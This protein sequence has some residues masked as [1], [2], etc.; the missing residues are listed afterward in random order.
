MLEITNDNVI[1]LTKGDTGVINI[2]VSGS[3]L[4]PESELVFTVRNAQNLDNI[5]FQLTETASE[6]GIIE[7]AVNDTAKWKVTIYGAATN[8]LKRKKYYY[9]FAIVTGE[10]GDKQT[11]VGG[12]K[13]K[14]EFWVT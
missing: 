2:Q 6:V 5:M 1:Y 14:L 10:S 8:S 11:F 4:M 12:G 7:K 3:G 9:D 13:D